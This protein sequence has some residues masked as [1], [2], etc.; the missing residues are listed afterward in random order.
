[1][2]VKKISLMVILTML[3]SMLAIVNT[4]NAA[5]TKYDPN[6]VVSYA[7][8]WVGKDYPYGR[9]L[10]FVA[11]CFANAYVGTSRSSACCAYKYG[12]SYIDSTS[13]SNIPIGADVFFGGSSSTCGTCGNKCGHIGIYVGNGEIVH[14]WNYKIAKTTIDKVVSSGY[15]YRGWGW[16]G[17]MSFSSSTPTTSNSLQANSMIVRNSAGEL[18]LYKFNGSSFSKPTK[19]G[20]GWDFTNY[21]P[22]HWTNNDQADDLMVRNSSGE[23]VLY[24]FN[25][26]SFSKPT[27]VGKGWDFTHYFP[28]HWTN[29][30]QADDLM[31]RNSAGELVL[32]TFNGSSFSKPTKVGNGWNFTHYFPG[33]WTNNNQVNDLM[34]RNSAGELVLYQFDGSSFSKPIKVGNGWDF[35]H[36]F[37]KDWNGDGITDLIVRTIEGDLLFYTFNGSRFSAPT[38]VG[39]SWNFTHYFPGHWVP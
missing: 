23:L 33:H 31:V 16:H 2:V 19:V 27:K 29:N 25:G 13:R 28:G 34:V 8:D 20:K 18:V 37:P 5:T 22:G 26:S 12:S 3:V 10:Q 17:N 15:T 32:Y 38:K 36:Y 1:M 30:D 6:I 14:A 4:S 35:T 24:P 21:F 39:N 11:D 7:L 9:C